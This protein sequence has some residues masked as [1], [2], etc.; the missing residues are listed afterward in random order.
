M[1]KF[2]GG[3]RRWVTTPILISCIQIWGTG[4]WGN[5]VT[6]NLGGT[7]LNPTLLPEIATSTEGGVDLNMFNNRLRFDLTYYDRAN[8]NQIFTFPWL[9]RLAGKAKISTPV[10]S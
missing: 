7:L 4:N 10:S 8:T 2:A 6:T 3:G 5:L 9:P 1:L